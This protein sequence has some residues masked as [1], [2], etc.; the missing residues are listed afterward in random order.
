MQPREKRLAYAGAAVVVVFVL[1]STLGNIFLAP[2]RDREN[3]ISSETI[4]VRALESKSDELLSAGRALG[5]YRAESLPPDPLDAQREYQRWL[6]DLAL[7]SGWKSPKVTLLSRSKRGAATVIP[8]NIK[9]QATLDDAKRFLERLESTPVLQRVTHLKFDSPGFEGNP[10]LTVDLTTEGLAVSDADART[11]LFPTAELSSDLPAEATSFTVANAIGFPETTPFAV[12]L[13]TELIEVQSVDGDTWTVKRGAHGSS[14]AAH[15][16]A[17]LV[18]LTPSRAPAVAERAHP[19]PTAQRLFVRV[20]EA[21]RLQIAADL[22]PAIRGAR[23]STALTVRNWDPALG[24]PKFELGSA[25][26]AG[27]SLDPDDGELA[28]TPPADFPLGPASIP[29]A[30]FGQDAESPE[31]ESKL[32]VEVRRPNQPP[33]LDTPSTASV[34]LGRPWQLTAA[35]TDPDLPNDTLKFSLGGNVPQGLTINAQTGVLSWS[36]PAETDLGEFAVEV[37]VTDAGQPAASDTGTIT[38][39]LADDSAL[40]TYLVGTV[41]VNGVPEAWLYDRSSNR[42]TT[43][44]TGDQ[45]QVADIVG[46]V[47]RIEDEWVEIES[48]GQTYRLDFNRNLR[49]WTQTTSTGSPANPAPPA[50]SGDASGT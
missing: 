15:S 14:P 38:L 50:S 27:M 41:Q 47:R 11:R 9:A 21:G 36:P 40:Y 5:R 13:D 6:T 22:Q 24:R 46:T 48:A 30:V 20:P 4:D 43:V 19:A 32:D 31:V 2:L 3:T 1:Q 17:A 12:R 33:Q 37:T 25:A 34:W 35:V 7:L 44:R 16:A 28:W 39:Q 26:P 18:E 23:W 42:R 45:V 29:I 8:I 10:L 49:E